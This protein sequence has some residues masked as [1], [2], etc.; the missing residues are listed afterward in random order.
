[1]ELNKKIP[2]VYSV[3]FKNLEELNI[4]NERIATCSNCTLCLQSKSPYLST[5]CCTYQPHLANY[6]VGGIFQSNTQLGVNILTKQIKNSVGVTPYGIIPSKPYAEKTQELNSLDFWNRPYELA[7]EQ[8]CPFY[9][10]GNCSIWE[11]R[12]NL[13]VTHFCA[14]SGGKSGQRFWKKLNQY[15]QLTETTLSQYAML[16]LGWPAAEIK[17]KKVSTDDFDFEDEEGNIIEENYEKLWRDW[18]GREEEFYKACYQIVQDLSLEKFHEMMG[19]NGK[20]LEQAILDTHKD[21]NENV[22]P[23]YMQLHPG[24]VFENKENGEVELKLGNKKVS[25]PGV[26]LP[27]LKGFNGKRSTV[28]VYH[29]GFKVLFNLE[30]TVEQLRQNGMLIPA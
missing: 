25:I 9:D 4:P 30:G 10:K 3:F 28:E 26:A 18:A 7:N 2:R 19:L 1:M 15:I 13:C 20:I 6:L 27:I 16:E 22:L 12:E 11:Y 14:S 23:D 5:K 17:T 24:L 29:L 8:L 21:F